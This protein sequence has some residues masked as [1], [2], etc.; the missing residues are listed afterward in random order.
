MSIAKIEQV[1]IEK[2]RDE[3]MKKS[4][5]EIEEKIKK[6]LDR[7]KETM[8]EK[9]DSLYGFE[10]FEEHYFKSDLITAKKYEEIIKK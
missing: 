5:I 4:N 9:N 3:E 2:I 10:I 6:Q 1:L 8:K 7:F